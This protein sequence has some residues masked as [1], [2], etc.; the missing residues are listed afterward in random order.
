MSRDGK[1]DVARVLST[2]VDKRCWKN[3]R[4]VGNLGT[5]GHAVVRK[6]YHALE[7]WKRQEDP[8]LPTTNKG[9]S[10]LPHVIK[11]DLPHAYR[12][13]T[14]QH[15]GQRLVLFLGNHDD[16]ERCLLYTS[17]AADE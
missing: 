14:Y 5:T 16:T 11:Y 6:V 1:S 2:H 7:C 15:A 13:V 10:R 3:L 4:D 8:A 17:D 9:E 12:L